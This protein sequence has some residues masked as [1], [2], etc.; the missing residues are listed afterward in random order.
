MYCNERDNMIEHIHNASNNLLYNIRQM[1]NVDSR[2]LEQLLHTIEECNRF[3]VSREV[4]R[5]QEIQRRLQMMPR[6][7][8]ASEYPIPG[9]TVTDRRTYSTLPSSISQMHRRNTNYQRDYYQQQPPV[10]PP[11]TYVHQQQV[12]PQQVQRP[13][14]TPRPSVQPSVVQQQPQS[15]SIL[16][17][18]MEQA[19]RMQNSQNAFS[20]EQMDDGTH[21]TV[22]Q[23]G[24]SV[25]GMLPI[26]DLFSGDSTSTGPFQAVLDMLQQTSVPHTLQD[27]PV[28]L[29]DEYLRQI[30]PHIYEA[31]AA[32][33]DVCAVCQNEFA[34]S[35]VC[36]ELPC[37]HNFH[38]TC[39]D[40]WFQ[41]HVTCPMCRL[42]M[43]DI[44][45]L[46]QETQTTERQEDAPLDGENNRSFFG[47]LQMR[48]MHFQTMRT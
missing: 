8:T 45:T 31:D 32:N 27:Q 24:T 16:Q 12:V 38:S 1:P 28:P 40:R 4:A 23:F 18:M 30:K 20:Q 7:R 35:E 15:Q 2:S 33:D 22:Q 14:T 11:R 5:R 41:E 6:V 19:T 37:T 26:S 10:P 21:V 42:D 36:R 47:V 43:R 48:I 39:I 25:S 13:V 44:I 3:V 46:P 9:G 34:A 29:P 17:Q